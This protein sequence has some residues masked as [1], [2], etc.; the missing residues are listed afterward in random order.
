MS[1]KIRHPA[2]TVKMLPIKTSSVGISSPVDCADG[3]E[4]M[5]V[6]WARCLEWSS[7]FSHSYANRTLLYTQA[8]C[9]FQ[10]SHAETR[11][12]APNA[13]K[14]YDIGPRTIEIGSFLRQQVYDIGT[15]L[16]KTAFSRRPFGQGKKSGGLALAA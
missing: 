10:T 11:N 15:L 1:T 4:A 2:T 6:N 8:Q 13:R 16:S 3:R 14:Y 7:S 9:V 5:P 12:A